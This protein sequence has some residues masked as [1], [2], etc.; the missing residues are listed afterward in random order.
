MDEAIHS[1]ILGSL[2]SL[3]L[4]LPGIV[5]FIQ[6]TQPW[7]NCT[8]SGLLKQTKINP[9]TRSVSAAP[10]LN[11]FG[12]RWFEIAGKHK[13]TWGQTA[14]GGN[15]MPA[16]SGHEQSLPSL[17]AAKE[18]FQTGRY[19]RFTSSS[20]LARARHVRDMNHEICMLWVEMLSS[21]WA[22]HVKC[23]HLESVGAVKAVIIGIWHTGLLCWLLSCWSCLSLD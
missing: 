5:L 2:P 22:E 20:K 21:R 11:W 15:P 4:L 9:F 23:A 14:C 7:C 6:S 13:G 10:P 16:R 1:P 19:C 8:Q 3:H 18:E 17:S 12:E